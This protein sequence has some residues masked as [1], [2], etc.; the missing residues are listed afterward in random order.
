MTGLAVIPVKVKAPGRANMVKTY[1]S[2]EN[3]SNTSFFSE[4]LAKKL[5]LSGRETSLS[6][7]TM[8]KNIR[9]ECVVVSLEVLDIDEENIV[10]LPVVFTRPK[11]PVSVE[12]AAKREDIDPWPHLAGVTVHK[13]E[14]KLIC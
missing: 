2:L 4:E 6:L 13:I 11:L 9:T 7:T 5:G 1:T 8:E 3:G 10:E 12:T 14:Q